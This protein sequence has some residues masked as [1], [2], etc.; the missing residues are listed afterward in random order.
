MDTIAKKYRILKSLGQGAMG[1][2]F[3]VLPPRGDPV[4]L[5][6]LKTLDEK[7]GKNASEQF[8]NEFKVLK[9]LSHPNIGRIYDY[10]YDET[11]NKVFFTMPW[12]KGTDIYAATKDL[13]FE[14]CEEYFVQTLRALNTLHQK[15]LFHC[16][17]KPGNIYVEDGKALLIDFGLAGYFGD[18]IVGT[19]TYLAPE[20]YQ[21]THH[22][23][24]SDLYATG[25]IF[26]NCLTRTQP[27][28]GKT[29]QE[30][31]DRHRTLT[32][33]PIHEI[34]KKVP[35]YFADIVATLLNKK[36]EERFPSAAA[37]IEEIAAFSKKKYSVETDETLLSYLPTQSEMI[38]N[39]EAMLDVQTALAD[40]LS[41]ESGKPYHVLFLHGRKNVGK[42]RVANRIVNELQ[43]AKT[44][45]ERALPPFQSGDRDILMEA[46]AVVIE[47][48]DTYTRTQDDRNNLQE[49]AT[50]I[51]QKIVAPETTQFLMVAT[52]Q[53][54]G[55]FA[56]LRKLFPE[57]A[58]KIWS[59]ALAPYTKE[60]TREFLIGIIGQSEIPQTFVD[61]FYRNTEGLPDVASELIQS[62]IEK[63]LLFDKSGR[64]NEDLLAELDKA[65]DSIEVSES[66]E[67]EFERAYASFN[68]REET[69]VSWLSLCP[70]GLTT[71]QLVELTGLT[72][73][74][75]TFHDLS[76]RNILR[77]E[78]RH[79]SLSRK[80][81]QDFV[82]QNLPDKEVRRRHTRLALPKTGLTPK[83][84]MYHLSL[85]DNA[86]LVVRA[87]EKL[88][89]LQ[90]RDGERERAVETYER[91]LK[92]HAS[93]AVG[94][95]LDWVIECSSLLIWLDRFQEA[96]ELLGAMEKEL[97]QTKAPVEFER[98]LVFIE[99]K[100]LALLHRHEFDRAR[101][102]F[103]NGMRSAEKDAAHLVHMLRFQNDLAEI[104][105]HTG[106]FDRAIELFKETRELAQ[107]LSTEQ[108][109]KLTNNDL[110]HVYLQREEHDKSLAIL[111]EDM[112]NFSGM[113]NKEPL[114][115][116]LY[117]YAHVLSSGKD[118][119]KAILAFEECIRLCK[120]GH[121]R[122]LLLRTYNG[123]GN[124]YGHMQNNAEALKNYQKALD[125]SVRLGDTTS[126]AALLFNQAYIYRSEKNFALALRRYLLA[127]QVLENKE[128]R[129]AYD[130]GLLS[131][132]YN[133]LAILS[134]QENNTMK[135]LSYL[136][137][138]MKLAPQLQSEERF[139]LKYDL[140]EMYMQTRLKEQ[141]LRE[142]GEL[143]LMAET[144]A[145]NEKIAK[146]EQEWRSVDNFDVQEFTGRIEIRP[147]A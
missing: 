103:K 121:F 1:E 114:A 54:E 109:Q 143:K 66:L 31:F 40:F 51:E 102:Y 127:I 119:D 35:K 17:L 68:E 14:Q 146:L 64:W 58:T 23:V 135:A 87:A 96:I 130:N 15:N 86:G 46:K 44:S 85:G 142:L 105:L 111:A 139:N 63:G 132:C 83:W 53:E 69:L 128:K 94:K 36:A 55:D 89:Q 134:V 99:K 45:V 91:L 133:G 57:E 48:V 4:A 25:V 79:V 24:L 122:P 61:Q 21:G 6:L 90:E 98:F 18:F 116:V 141:F 32:P 3:L 7:A 22:N 60:E 62:M 26:Y 75:S 80:I 126:K 41:K 117:S 73:I 2:V 16:D 82:R 108:L 5:K 106:N 10:G 88:A 28:S 131:R 11:S 49:F 125:L 144:P 65:L 20:I 13:P 113:A 120:K 70:H 124:L 74:E 29:L 78:G 110:G 67:Q 123:L 59:I 27:F 112:R 84:A 33:P 9:R 147:E 37:V 50:L 42:A 8:E 138:R 72:A 107:G 76:K 38:G 43:L 77:R 93:Q 95:R 129:L 34:N 140:T 136:L 97:Q 71:E 92:E 104:E 19:P 30:V 81:F 47:N 52:S 115:R 137:E 145:Q 101:V 118:Y 100:G 39:K 12:L 56:D